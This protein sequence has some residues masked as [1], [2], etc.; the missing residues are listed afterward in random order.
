MSTKS[1]RAGEPAINRFL[2]SFS[3]TE[4][5]H[6]TSR[7]FTY[8]NKIKAYRLELPGEPTSGD[9]YTKASKKDSGIVTKLNIASD[10][11]TGAYFFFGTNEAAPGYNLQNDSVMR[12]FLE[13]MEFLQP[14]S[15]RGYLKKISKYIFMFMIPYKTISPGLPGIDAVYNPC[16]SFTSYQV[17]GTSFT[18]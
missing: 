4:K 14:W 6:D 13:N 9:D 2:Q 10:P 8:T 1:G 17:N 12:R 7:I 15:C 11:L 18:L 16:S 3:I 5:A